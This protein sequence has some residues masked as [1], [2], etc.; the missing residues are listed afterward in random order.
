MSREIIV[1]FCIV[2]M[3]LCFAVFAIIYFRYAKSTKTS[4]AKPLFETLEENYSN[5]RKHLAQLD[6]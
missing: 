2:N 3:A 6:Q 5:Y 1:M 4:R